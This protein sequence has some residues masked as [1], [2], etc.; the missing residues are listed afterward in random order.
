MVDG[1]GSVSPGP[2]LV[3]FFGS[4]SELLLKLGPCCDYLNT[5]RDLVTVW[6]QLIPQ[7]STS[8]T[9][10]R[11]IECSKLGCCRTRTQQSIRHI[12]PSSLSIAGSW[13]WPISALPTAHPGHDMTRLCAANGLRT[14]RQVFQG[15]WNQTVPKKSFA[16][17][18]RKPHT[19]QQPFLYRY[20]TTPL[21]YCLSM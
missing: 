10:A 5:C 6:P 9:L 7:V 19:R 20:R 3:L 14:Y 4:D 12:P 21:L 18:I 2:L 17:D 15:L 8:S 13:S 11:G 16:S 1:T